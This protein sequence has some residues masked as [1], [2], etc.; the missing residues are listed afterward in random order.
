MKIK[1]LKL[2][3]NVLTFVGLV[4]LIYFT[5][6]QI[7]DAFKKLADLNFFWLILIIPLQLLNYFSVAKFYQTY[8]KGLGSEVPIKQLYRASLEMNFVNNVFPSGGVSGFGYLRSRLRRIG[9]PSS[10]STLT[11]LSRHSLTF[12]SFII[13]LL[14]AIF[15]LAIFGNAS[16]IMVAVSVSIIF[17]VIIGASLMIYLISSANRIKRFM[18]ALPNLINKIFN[19]FKRKKKPT[20]DVERIEELFGQLHHDYLHVRRNW[21]SLKR[22]F[23]WTML[24]NLTELSTIFTVYLAFGSLVNPGA[25]I[26]AYAVASM[27]GLVA[28][29]PGGVGVY[30]GLMT[31]ILA[32]A[33]IPKALAISAT[34]VYRVLTMVIFLPI[35]FILYQI[36]LRKDDEPTAN[37]ITN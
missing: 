4:A 29:L 13:Y 8:L 10:K 24:M 26:V 19:V 6:V 25:I 3:I 9:V 20:I 22:P 30:E 16:R 32:S 37:D 5:R 27:A 18:A 1:S 31:A 36:A 28:V 33:G 14:V 7:V 17:L 35:G 11:Q 15:L 34:L 12:T 2:W 23:I 21:R